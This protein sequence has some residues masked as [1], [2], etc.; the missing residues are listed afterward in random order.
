MGPAGVMAVV[1]GDVESQEAAVVL[2]YSVEALQT[3]AGR[4]IPTVGCGLGLPL[5][6]LASLGVVPC[7]RW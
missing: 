4:T 6:A 3:A 1:S 7:G 2:Y 5:Q